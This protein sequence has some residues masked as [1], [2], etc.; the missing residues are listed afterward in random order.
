MRDKRAADP[1]RRIDRPGPDLRGI[2]RAAELDVCPVCEEPF[3][4][5][6]PTGPQCWC[7]GSG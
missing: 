3:L 4:H 6:E 1:K 5:V 2:E 7:V